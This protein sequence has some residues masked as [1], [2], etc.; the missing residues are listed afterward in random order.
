MST[1]GR[2][3]VA[4]GDHSIAK[5]SDAD[6][7]IDLEGEGDEISLAGLATIA[8]RYRTWIVAASVLLGSLVLITGLRQSR[9]FTTSASFVPQSRRTTL[10]TGVSGIASQFGLSIPIADPGQSPQFYVDLL[11]SDEILRGLLDSAYTVQR[12]SG[13]VR[14]SLPQW[15]GVNASS[16]PLEAE[17]TVQALRKV[18]TAGASLKTG[19]I[20]FSVVAEHPDLAQQIAQRLLDRLNS[21]NLE[22][23]A[24]QAAMERRF[25]EARLAE[26]QDDLRASENRLQD[27]MQENRDFRSSARLSMDQERLQRDVAMRQQ[28]YTAL[29]QAYEQ[30]RL[31]ELRD[32]PVI[33]I[34]ER[35]RAAVIPNSRGL[36]RKIILAILVGAFLA[37]GAALGKEYFARSDRV[38]ASSG[39]ELKAVARE[40][41]ADIRHP[42]R[43]IRNRISTT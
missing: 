18:I 39:A 11:S 20:S 24:S 12:G 14:G 19:V 4:S 7:R 43:A 30:A 41:F 42:L 32:T 37:F 17:R 38:P 5:H 35:P 13:I 10:P 16:L 25:T 34:L 22:S 26:V 29:A 40:A 23:R 6:K 21:F 15:M 33:T 27:F 1:L 9:T 28:V 36:L 8:L 31:E 3:E 2:Q